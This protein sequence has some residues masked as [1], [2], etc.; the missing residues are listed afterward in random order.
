MRLFLDTANIEHIRHGVRL[1]VISGV[2]TN[3]T[4][5][6]RE[7]KVD[8]QK[9]VQEICS[10]VPGPVSTEVL[11]Q[12]VAGMITEAREIARW[13]E[14]IVVKIPASLD[15]VEATSVLAK[16]NIKV[17]FT[18]CFSLNQ[19]ILG[20]AAGATF[21]SPFVGRLDDVGEDGIRVVAD[22]VEYLEY[23]QLPTQVIAASIRHPQHC[24]A[25]A[26]VGAHIAT[27][28]YNVL[29]QMIQHPL[30]DTGIKRFLD[31][32]KRTQQT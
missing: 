5:V 20:A 30:T 26:K 24:L 19:A 7:G 31:D 21:V 32:W 9:L 14:N 13:A 15:G 10:I 23:Y 17:N 25:A 22:I 27:V 3:P 18:L 11:S 12:D 16:E 2:T 28:P 1:G 29:L 6:S 8:Y 4:I